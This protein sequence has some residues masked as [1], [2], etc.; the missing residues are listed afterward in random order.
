M[1]APRCYDAATV[2]DSVASPSFRE[3]PT[4]SHPNHKRRRER[5]LCIE[6]LESRALLS[7]VYHSK[8][9]MG[10]GGIPEVGT[11]QVRFFTM[12]MV[13]AE[14][15]TGPTGK[16]FGGGASKFN[17]AA[18]TT[19]VTVKEGKFHYT[20]GTAI[21]TSAN[22]KNKL[23]IAYHGT[24]TITD[25]KDE[26]KLEGHVIGGEGLFSSQTKGQFDAN[27][28]FFRNKGEALVGFL[29]HVSKV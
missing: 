25:K 2:R 14:P 20:N 17:G 23:V 16:A 21:L 1:S 24:E 6:A 7:T 19:M 4:M 10:V 12:G 8:K 9:M 28:H 3:G 15:A 18:D 26:F 27:G 22:E 11:R 29:V 13:I 5:T